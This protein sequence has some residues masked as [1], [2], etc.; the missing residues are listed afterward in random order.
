MGS[1]DGLAPWLFVF[2]EIKLGALS[3]AQARQLREAGGF[4]M[5]SELMIDAMNLFWALTATF[6]K[7]PAEKSLFTHLA[8]LRDLFH[9]GVPKTLAWVDTRDM[10]A[11]GMTKGKIAREAILEL[12][13][14]QYTL[15]HPAKRFS[16]ICAQSPMQA[17]APTTS[18][19]DSL[20][21][22]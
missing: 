16:P 21:T 19:P 9:T 4:V 8:W 18:T 3:S 11:D 12:M 7:L 13:S 2:Q 17:Q 15:R 10:Y 1:V 6:P 14:G 22:S 5:H 20:G